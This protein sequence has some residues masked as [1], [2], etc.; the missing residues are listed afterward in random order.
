MRTWLLGCRRCKVKLGLLET[1]AKEVGVTLILTWGVG[2][3]CDGAFEGWGK[4]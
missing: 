4:G 3:K 1:V 2:G